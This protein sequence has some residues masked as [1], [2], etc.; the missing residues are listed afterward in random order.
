LLEPESAVPSPLQSK[1]RGT[2][3]RTHGNVAESACCCIDQ[4]C[5]LAS[6]LAYPTDSGTYRA[7][8]LALADSCKGFLGTIISSLLFLCDP[9]PFCNHDG[10]LLC[11]NHCCMVIWI[12]NELLIQV[13]WN[14]F[15]I[16]NYRFWLFQ[17]LKEL[18]V[19]MKEQVVNWW[20]NW[21]LFG[22]KKKS[23][24]LRTMDIY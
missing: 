4:G 16:Q 20:F 14:E 11:T 21:W 5:N 1:G 7:H 8:E 17:H 18:M 6:K 2:A 22:R 24:F 19:F 13:P 15:I 9:Y 23:I 10:Y 3:R 12:Y